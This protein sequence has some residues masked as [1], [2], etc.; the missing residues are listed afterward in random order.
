MMCVASCC[1]AQR[2]PTTSQTTRKERGKKKWGVIA[3]TAWSLL[4]RSRPL[5]SPSFSS[6]ENL[7]IPF[8]VFNILS[9]SLN[10]FRFFRVYFHSRFPMVYNF[11]AYSPF[12]FWK[13]KK[14]KIPTVY[15]QNWEL[16]L[17]ATWVLNCFIFLLSFS[18][19]FTKHNKPKSHDL[20]NLLLLFS[21]F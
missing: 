18:K 10:I 8:Q 1:C 20:L 13:K 7:L 6:M 5:S 19:R 3:R 2:S 16:Q 11:F 17:V 21:F 12:F 15:H 9:L 14:M 4:S